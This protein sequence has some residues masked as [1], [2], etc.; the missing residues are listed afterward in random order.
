MSTQIHPEEILDTLRSLEDRVADLEAENERLR[1]QL[2]DAKSAAGK[3]RARIRK[4]HGED[5]EDLRD[6]LRDEKRQ[7][8]QDDGRI[9]RRLS[10]VEEELEIDADD[11]LETAANGHQGQAM[12]ALARLLEYGPEVAVE[13]PT[14][15]HYRARD[16][17]EKFNEEAWGTRTNRGGE[18]YRLLRS[19]QDDL[20]TRLEDVRDESLQW[21]QVYRALEWIAE[22]SE[23]HVTLREGNDTEGRYVLEQRLHRKGGV[24]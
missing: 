22:N 20:K 23:G 4:E 15:T 13:R 18:R 3:D 16:I 2:E 9:L 14:A 17:A 8:G 5:V 21:N 11:A 24:E 10:A 19:K 7:R 12:T 6:D 1:E